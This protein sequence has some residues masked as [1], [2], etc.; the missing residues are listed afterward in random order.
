MKL[1]PAYVVRQRAG[2]GECPMWS[3]RRAALFGSV[4]A[5][6]VGL[7]ALPNLAFGVV[8]ST[9]FWAKIDGYSENAAINTDGFARLEL[10]LGDSTDS[11]SFCLEFSGLSANL[12]ASH[13]HLARST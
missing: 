2:T 5:C 9:N 13:I 4:L 7:F 11:I 6:T 8:T 3:P 12:N 1:A 10:R